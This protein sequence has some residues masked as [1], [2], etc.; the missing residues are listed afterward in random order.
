MF[1]CLSCGNSECV[2][3]VNE[4]VLIN[5]IDKSCSNRYNSGNK[6]NSF[7]FTVLMGCY[8]CIIEDTTD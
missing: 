6:L 7:S 5:F 8:K 3:I 1:Y 4:Y 2:L